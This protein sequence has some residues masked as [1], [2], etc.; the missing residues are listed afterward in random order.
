M[1]IAM[2]SF[3]FNLT[4]GIERSSYEVARGL[5]ADG[6]DVTLVASDVT[7]SPVGMHWQY[8]R[9]PI[10]PSWSVPVT[11]PRAAS[12]ALRPGDF[13]VVHNQGGCAL[14]EQDVITAHSCHRAWWEMKRRN[15][16]IA[17]AYLNPLHHAVLWTEGRN[18][19]PGAYRHVIAVSH[20]VG[21]EVRDHYGVPEDRITVV[22]NGVDLDAFAR[23]DSEEARA[24]TRARYGFGSDDVAVLFVGKEFRRKGLA[25]L[26]AAL[27]S[28]PPEAR[29]LVVGGDDQVPY[30]RLAQEHGVGDRVVFVG[31]TDAVQ[32]CFAAA[33]VFA[34]PTLYEA[35]ALVS[36]E[37]AAAGLP[38]VT[39]K[40]NGTEDFVRPGANGMLVERDPASL[41]S[42]LTPLVADRHL[43]RRLGEQARVDVLDYSWTAVAR[44]TAEVYAHVAEE[45]RAEQ[46]RR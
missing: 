34:L 13:D 23:S 25:P 1:K 35:F 21:R 17:R 18:Y 38:L 19:R 27:P 41:A 16:E 11:Y 45:K 3:R 15:G 4:G 7:P 42:A 14:L 20:G 46:G 6:H 22:P 24:R 40:V 2:S 32:D 28:L 44:R 29:L 10:G 9:A 43:R 39:T 31:H 26:V 5:V 33:D 36:L 12:R 8:V 37:A 30:R